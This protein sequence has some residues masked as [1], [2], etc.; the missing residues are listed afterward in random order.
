MYVPRKLLN[1][2][3]YLF[4]SYDLITNINTSFSRYAHNRTLKY[5]GDEQSQILQE[6]SELG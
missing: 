1:L 5:G 3:V 4:T 2:S 6:R